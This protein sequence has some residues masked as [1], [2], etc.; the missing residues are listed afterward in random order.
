[1]TRRREALGLALVLLVALGLR[2]ARWSEERVQPLGLVPAGDER[3]HDQW[4]QRLARGEGPPAVPYTA[5][6]QA[7]SLAAWHRWLPPEAARDGQRGLQVL[8]GLGTVA[9]AWALGR[10]LGG[11]RAGLVAGA[12]VALH[13]PLVYYEV[14]LLRD[15]PATCLT[16]L[17]TLALVRLVPSRGEGPSPVGAALAGLAWGVG[18]LWRE[19]LL[20]VALGALL[21]LVPWALSVRPRRRG[22]LLLLVGAAGLF[23]PLAPLLAHNARLEGRWSLL[24]TWN[25]GCVFY[26]ANRGDHAGASYA[27]PPFL[28]RSNREAEQEGFQLEATRRTGRALTPHEVSSFWLRRGLLDVVADP[29]LYASKVARRTAWSLAT[30]ELV[31]ARDLPLDRQDS[32]VLRLPGVG[33]GLLAGFALLGAF[34]RRRRLE[35]RVLAALALLLLSSTVLVMFASRHR[36]PLVPLAAALAA[37]GAR[38]AVRALRAGRPGR[39]LAG[40][41]LALLCTWIPVPHTPAQEATGRLNRALVWMELGQAPRAFAELAAI[42]GPGERGLAWSKLALVLLANEEEGLAREASR[43]AVQ[44]VPERGPAL[45]RAWE[46]LARRRELRG[47][48]AGAREAQ[49]EAG[50]LGGAPYP[51]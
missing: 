14:T 16:T 5:P 15:G 37:L 41:L 29:G 4:A 20:L 39:L 1:M 22:L 10:R 51:R 13:L 2:L 23:L 28:R 21:L 18:A 7:W 26:I 32:L 6:L 47:D 31:D 44:L 38:D 17:A 48:A 46:G 12:A 25:G 3:D 34:G 49:R 35:V 33:F 45:V 30:S 36:L 8:L 50:R 43:R 11:P 24:H 27:R 19:N 42:D 40:T 9:L